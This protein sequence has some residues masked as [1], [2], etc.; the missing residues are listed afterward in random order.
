L[1]KPYTDAFLAAGLFT[2][3]LG[4]GVSNQGSGNIIVTAGGTVFGA[5][6]GIQTLAGGGD[7]AI[8]TNDRV[9][10]GQDGI[11]ATA[12]GIGNI[13][14][15]ADGRVVGTAGD[16]IVTSAVN[17][18]TAI[19][20]NDRVAGGDDGIDA[21]ATGAG[22]IAVTVSG[23]VAG[24]DDG[25]HARTTTG[26]IGITGSGDVTGD[27]DG[28]GGGDGID[29]ASTAGGSIDVN[30]SG[31]ITGDPGIILSVVGAGTI[32]LTTGG[33]VVG[34]DG[35]GINTSAV[36]GDT[37]ITANAD[38]TGGEDG[39]DATATGAGDIGIVADAGA[40][41]TGATGSGV[42][43]TT[44]SGT[45]AIDNSGL[46]QG[47]VAAISG[48]TGTLLSIANH[49]GGVIQNLTGELGDLAIS[50]T[51]GGMTEIDNEF[52]GSIVG[53]IDTGDGDDTFTNSGSWRTTGVSDFGAG[54][55][56]LINQGRITV[57]EQA[58]VAEI[59]H[60]ANLDSF[61]NASA[62]VIDLVDENAPNVRDTLTIDGV[63]AGQP[64]SSVEL[65]LA[66]V[67]GD[68]HSGSDLLVLD[69]ADSAQGTTDFLFNIVSTGA[70]A[71]TA[72]T[73]RV[74]FA[75]GQ[76]LAA[77]VTVVENRGTL[78]TSSGDDDIPLAR[79]GLIN[80]NLVNTAA[81]GGDYQVVSELDSGLTGGILLPIHATLSV[82][83]FL[84]QRTPNPITAT[85]I[86][87]ENKPNAQGGWARA[88]GGQFQTES[89]GEAVANG[90]TSGLESRD[91]TR[92]A[93]IQG[94]FDYVLCNLDGNGGNL[95]LG[96]T[97]G[98]TWGAMRQTDPDPLAGVFGTDVDF[99]T[100][101]VGP[102]AAYTRGNL[103]ILT[104]LRFDHHELEL[105]N[106]TA[107]IDA[108]GIDFDASGVSG[109]AAVSYDFALDSLIL[110]PEVGVNVSKVKLDEFGVASGTVFLDDLWSVIGHAGVTARSTITVTDNV[111][112]IPFAAAT[113]YHEFVE[114][115][116]AKLALGGTTVDAES[117]RV[118][119]YGQVGIG[120]NAVRLGDVVAGRP[121]LFGGARVDLQ[122]GDRLQGATAT[123][124]G[125]VQF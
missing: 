26:D 51:G 54:S 114:T 92:F 33:P 122:F 68:P 10:G 90:T 60:L 17:G 103:A 3:G 124:F 95:H 93:T 55:D 74:G 31:A 47:A 41:V 112:V 40:T 73:G 64:G 98:Q 102:Y 79:S 62:G 76:M 6:V 107:G 82:A 46:L 5:N 20:T 24:G 11:Y 12:T 14:I 72:D 108:A 84:T 9:A 2:T 34:T 96:V 29:A 120:A 18:D 66:L 67:A 39:I 32:D 19:T 13:A 94:G 58:A 61:M 52:G 8:T 15:T 91:T 63:Y 65:D 75:G 106:Q 118:G 36:D 70:T 110:T 35:D 115:A 113:L 48:A 85:C 53:R 87:P 121:T 37:T 42:K 97:V 56:S 105:S 57:A 21:T 104:A 38:V 123:V 44:N 86:D 109:S 30:V 116:G 88:F 100:F 80:Y 81:A 28:V 49:A 71:T 111:F 1:L 99:D 7:T 25:I 69:P 78:S 22:N 16:G 125:R 119:T 43:T 50:V 27:T 23:P 89:A 45:A 59:T 77:P 117:N 83:S 101:F 4:I